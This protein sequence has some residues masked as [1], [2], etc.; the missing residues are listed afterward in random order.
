MKILQ[1]AI[2][3]G[4]T[5]TLAPEHFSITRNG[6]EMVVLKPE[7][8]TDLFAWAS[9][10][11]FGEQPHRGAQPATVNHVPVR[12]DHSPTD[13]GSRTAKT[14]RPVVVG[15]PDLP[16]RTPDVSPDGRQAVH[17]LAIVD[18]AAE[19]MKAG[20]PLLRK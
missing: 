19:A 15:D 17:G 18:L 12:A 3:D 7:D 1:Q 16:S 2:I 8:A 11:I 10:L 4:Y 20:I 6:E 14:T 9:A 13:L 5:F